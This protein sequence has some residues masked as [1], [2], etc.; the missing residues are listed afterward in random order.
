MNFFWGKRRC[1][2]EKTK[3][4]SNLKKKI[5]PKLHFLGHILKI[6]TFIFMCMIIPLGPHLVQT[7]CSEGP[8]NFVKWFCKKLDHGSWTI[9]SDHGKKPSSMVRL[10]G[11]W[12]RPALSICDSRFCDHDEFCVV[13]HWASLCKIGVD[14]ALLRCGKSWWNKMTPSPRLKTSIL[15]SIE[16]SHYMFSKK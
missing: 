5:F 16:I 4:W 9:K 10:H 8:K 11:P 7:Y 6:C 15:I 2:K 3:I 1:K 12:C 13:L 14:F